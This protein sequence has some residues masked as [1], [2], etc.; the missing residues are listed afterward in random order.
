MAKAR[1]VS[2]SLRDCT[3]IEFETKEIEIRLSWS[4]DRHYAIRFEPAWEKERVAHVFHEAAQM[5]TRDT[6]LD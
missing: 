1:L 4:N 2:I 6:S 5:I 3:G